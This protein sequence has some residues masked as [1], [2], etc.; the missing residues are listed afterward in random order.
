MVHMDLEAFEA[1]INAAVGAELRG[2]RAKRG[3]TRPQLAKRAQLGISTI[4][5]IENGE[6]SPEI[7]QLARILRVLDV[8]LKD[9]V[10]SALKDIEDVEDVE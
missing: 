6:R 8:S 7:R 5:R 3:V 1:E 9:F 2:L 4:Q 10:A